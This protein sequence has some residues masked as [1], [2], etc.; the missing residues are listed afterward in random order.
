MGRRGADD[1]RPGWRGGS[2]SRCSARAVNRRGWEDRHILRRRL[3]TLWGRPRSRPAVALGVHALVPMIAAA[4]GWRAGDCRVW[5]DV[6]REHIDR[7]R[8]GRVGDRSASSDLR[9]RARERRRLAR[10]PPRS[11]EPSLVFASCWSPPTPSLRNCRTFQS[12]RAC[13]CGRMRTA[14]PVRRKGEAPAVARAKLSRQRPSRERENAA[15]SCVRRPTST[16]SS[17]PPRRTR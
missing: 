14:G 6:F 12:H 15:R 9:A 5:R 4:V 13:I 11:R 2:S 3:A 8:R 16:R 17:F 1:L 10:R 7:G